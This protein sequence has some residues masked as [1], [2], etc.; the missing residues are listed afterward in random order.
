MR[1][2]NKEIIQKFLTKTFGI[3][4]RSRRRGRIY[5]DETFS[6]T[7][8]TVWIKLIEDHFEDEEIQFRAMDFDSHKQL[9]E[10][11]FEALLNNRTP[12]TNKAIAILRD[13]R[14]EELLNED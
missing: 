5:S 4:L 6:I 2:Y 13:Q 12:I 14:L 3:T 10:V 7:S 9:F 8:Q 11:I 1:H